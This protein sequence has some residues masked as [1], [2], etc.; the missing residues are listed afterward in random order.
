MRMGVSAVVLLGAVLLAAPVAADELD[1]ARKAELTNL[2]RHDCGACHGLT[3]K[4]GLGPALTVERLQGR[5]VE[6]LTGI[7]LNGVPDT[8]M[9]PWGRY[10]TRAEANWLARQLKEERDAS[11]R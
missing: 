11:V 7:I 8:P 10:L 4:G 9:P 5:S 6:S 3:R 2:L 1:S